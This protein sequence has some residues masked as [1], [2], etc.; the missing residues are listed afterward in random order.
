METLDTGHGMEMTKAVLAMFVQKNGEIPNLTGNYNSPT[1]NTAHIFGDQNQ[2]LMRY[3]EVLLSRA[4]C[5]VRTGDVP[6]AMAD[7]KLV[8]D[9]GMGRNS[10]CQ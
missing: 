9:Q 1:D 6:G 8:R 4:E 3:A 10:T 7:L 5:K 2:I